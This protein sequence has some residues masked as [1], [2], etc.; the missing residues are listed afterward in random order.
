MYKVITHTIKEEHFTHPATVEYAFLTKNGNV[1]PTTGNITTKTA[2]ANTSRINRLIEYY[3]YALRNTIV[4]L[5]NSGED[6]AVTENELKNAIDAIVEY[7]KVTYAQN[8]E[9]LNIMP[10]ETYLKDY[11]KLLIEIAKLQK[12]GRAITDVE[13]QLTKNI[14]DFSGFLFIIN[15]QDWPKDDSVLYLTQ[16]SNAVINQIIA[17]KNK[18]WVTDQ[19]QFKTGYQIFISGVD[20]LP[21]SFAQYFANGIIDHDNGWMPMV[22]SRV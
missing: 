16:F 18:N 20:T 3:V 22:S 2:N 21:T 17:R 5:M 9:Q 19:A 7:F 1:V 15:S 6:L 8:N 12:I 13:L 4:S 11:T 14:D 10:F